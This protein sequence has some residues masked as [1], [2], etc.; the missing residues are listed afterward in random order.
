MAYAVRFS[1]DGRL[2]VAAVTGPPDWS[3]MILRFDSSSG[4]QVGRARQVARGPDG[5]PV[6]MLTR[7]GRRLVTT[8]EEGATVVRD[9]RTLRPLKRFPVGALA[10]ALSPDGRTMLAGSQRL[11]RRRPHRGHVHH[12]GVAAS[13]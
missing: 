2:L 4:R 9:A 11:L 5:L 6:L 10:A 13:P 8:F 12:R 3:K 1:P 7:D